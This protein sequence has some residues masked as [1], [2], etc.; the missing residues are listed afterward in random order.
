[1]N[2]FESPTDDPT[3]PRLTLT[4]MGR[5][6]AT[7]QDDLEVLLGRLEDQFFGAEC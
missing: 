7:S 4:I 1:M 2:S 5:N 6:L 3:A